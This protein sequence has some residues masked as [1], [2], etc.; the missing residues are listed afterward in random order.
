MRRSR[1]ARYPYEQDCLVQPANTSG[2]R[3]AVQTGQIGVDDNRIV[4]AILEEANCLRAV[5][6]NHAF[7]AGVLEQ[8]FEQLSV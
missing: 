8:Y 4:D 6:G 2:N 5:A 7:D 1:L 3:L